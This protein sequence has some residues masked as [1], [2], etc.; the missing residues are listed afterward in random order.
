[1]NLTV[2][3]EAYRHDGQGT[4][5]ELFRELRAE[6][7]RTAVMVNGEV[8]RKSRF[9]SVRLSDGDQVELIMITAGG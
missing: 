8:V 1:M 2:N 6:P 9:D 7:G 5:A 4:L 3:G